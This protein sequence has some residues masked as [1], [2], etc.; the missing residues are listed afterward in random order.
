M[1]KTIW[2]INTDSCKDKYGETSLGKWGEVY[3]LGKIRLTNNI[4]LPIRKE[5]FCYYI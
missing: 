2:T 5:G 4:L 3:Y 1:M